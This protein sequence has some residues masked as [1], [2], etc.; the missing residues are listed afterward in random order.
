MTGPPDIGHGAHNSSSKMI[1]EHDDAAQHSSHS[2]G[3][4]TSPIPLH[5]RELAVKKFCNSSDK[6]PGWQCLFWGC[7][8]SPGRATTDLKPRSTA[9]C[10]NT[11]STQPSSTIRRKKKSRLMPKQPANAQRL[12][13]QHSQPGG[14]RLPPNITSLF[15]TPCLRLHNATHITQHSKKK[16]KKGGI[17]N[18]PDINQL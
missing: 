8:L 4:T 1:S 9:C 11:G 17:R 6:R 7:S 13:A 10:P 2:P 14:H 12:T 18:K 5:R 3:P 15:G 16:S